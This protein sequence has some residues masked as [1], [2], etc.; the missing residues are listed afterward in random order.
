MPEQIPKKNDP[1]EFPFTWKGIPILIKY[2]ANYAASVVR[3]MGY[4]LAHIELYAKEPLPITESGYR[5][6]FLNH[7]IIEEIGD[8]KTYVKTILDENAILK[9]WKKYAQEKNQLRLF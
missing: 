3:I 5:S 8:V 6:I 4:Q 7:Q 1:V 2:Q 9:K